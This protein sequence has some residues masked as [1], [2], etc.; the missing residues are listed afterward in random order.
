MPKQVIWSPL[1]V[2]DFDNILDYLNGNWNEQV[3]LKFINEIE[4]LISNI[5]K[6]PKIFL[7][8]NKK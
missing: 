3:V 4:I 5:A 2:F 6:Q 8:V 7:L 1:A